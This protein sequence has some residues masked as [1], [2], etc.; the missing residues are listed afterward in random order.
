M[1]SK[2]FDTLAK[3]LA[4]AGTRRRLVRLLAVLPLAG[5]VGHLVGDERAH[6]EAPARGRAV[7]GDPLAQAQDAQCEAVRRRQGQPDGQA[8]RLQAQVPRQDL[9]RQ[10]RH[11]AQYLRQAGRL[12]SVPLRSA[13]SALPDL[14]PH[15]AAVRGR[16]RRHRVHGGGVWQ[17]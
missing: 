2:R 3:T 4:Q 9:R 17:L 10:M 16:D 13:L 5:A 11:G 12:W 6:G 14:Q 15:H 7:A 1:E 8:Q